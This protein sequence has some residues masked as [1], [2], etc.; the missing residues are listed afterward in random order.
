MPLAT[1]DDGFQD[2]H[3]LDVVVVG[4]RQLGIEP[5]GI[6]YVADEPVEPLHVVLDDRQQALAR[7]LGLGDWQRLDSAAQRGQRVLELVRGRRRAKRSIASMR[8]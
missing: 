8:L 3:E 6:R 5:R 4:A 2:L 1:G 7:G